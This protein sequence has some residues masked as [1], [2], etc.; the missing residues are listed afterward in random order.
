[1]IMRNDT[2]SFF[3]KRSTMIVAPILTSISNKRRNPLATP[4]E[5]E[6]SGWALSTPCAIERSAMIITRPK[7]NALCAR[8]FSHPR[9]RE[10]RI[11]KVG[12]IQTVYQAHVCLLYTSD[13]ADDLLCVDLGGRRII[14]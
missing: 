1:M 14:K 4:S 11:E 7:S 6:A 9:R 5:T 3:P 10:S 12:F 13:A 2:G 8:V